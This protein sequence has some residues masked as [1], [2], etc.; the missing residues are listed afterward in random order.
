MD[1][2]QIAELKERLVETTDYGAVMEEFL[3]GVEADETFIERG[4]HLGGTAS[5]PL[6]QLLRGIL[7]RAGWEIFGRP[8][9][10]DALMLVGVPQ[11]SFVHGACLL[12]SCVTNLIYFSDIG[13]GLLAV[14]LMD[15][16]QF[17]TRLIRFSAVAVVDP[18]R[19]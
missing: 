12:C 7:D 15:K 8:P 17:E 1:L 10:I 13:V 19:N 11:A 14:A 5:R 9:H 6:I 18:S 16:E 2:Q 4:G 3:A